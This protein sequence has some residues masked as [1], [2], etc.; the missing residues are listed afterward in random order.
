MPKTWHQTGGELCVL[1][2]GVYLKEGVT[3][4]ERKVMMTMNFGCLGCV[5]TV[6]MVIET[7]SL[8]MVAGIKGNSWKPDSHS[9]ALIADRNPRDGGN[10]SGLKITRVKLHQENHRRSNRG[11]VVIAAVVMA[12]E[13]S[14]AF[15]CGNNISVSR[16]LSHALCFKE[17]AEVLVCV[18]GLLFAATGSQLRLTEPS[19]SALASSCTLHPEKDFTFE[20]S[21]PQR[22]S[23]VSEPSQQK[24]HRIC[25]C[26][27]S[28]Q[29]PA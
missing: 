1:K 14:T 7:C 18:S 17:Q 26:S 21:S 23:S 24:E 4:R 16:A 6:E 27:L 5:Q 12:C 20:R 19:K 15:L 25:S 3:K 8:E 29:L 22:R 28:V 11:A 13:L 9:S 2:R 10:Y